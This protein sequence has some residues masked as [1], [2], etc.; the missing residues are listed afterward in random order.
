MDQDRE[1]GGRGRERGGEGMVVKWGGVGCGGM[2]G[3][4]GEGGEGEVREG[5]GGRRFWWIWRK[6]DLGS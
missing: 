5:N 2:G 3:E 1:E 6:L 4:G